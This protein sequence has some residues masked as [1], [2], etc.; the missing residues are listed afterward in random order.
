MG[1]GFDSLLL[2]FL[3]FFQLHVI[4]F[5]LIKLHSSLVGLEIALLAVFLVSLP[6]LKECYA[7]IQEV[8]RRALL[9]VFIRCVALSY[10]PEVIAGEDP[11]HESDNEAE[12]DHADKCA[13]LLIKILKDNILIGLIRLSIVR[14]ESHLH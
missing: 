6:G 7:S 11:E 4:V 3:Y 9:G 5:D 14:S 13:M 2:P 1:S 10:E 12:N 8:A